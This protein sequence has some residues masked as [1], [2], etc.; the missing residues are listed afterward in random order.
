MEIHD[1]RPVDYGWHIMMND[2]VDFFPCEEHI[3]IDEQTVNNH[4]YN[5]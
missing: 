1:S 2:D 5:L 3:K 4:K